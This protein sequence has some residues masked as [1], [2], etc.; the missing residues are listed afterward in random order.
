MYLLD[1]NVCIRFMTGRSAL[2]VRRMSGIA[3]TAVRLCS[4]VKAELL[5]GAR[6]SR[7]VA[8]NLAGLEEFWRPFASLPFDDIAAAHY[9]PIRAELSAAGTPIGPNDLMIAAIA[10]AHDLTLVTANTRE[11]RRVIGLRVEDWERPE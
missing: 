5:W 3:P 8:E 2:V 11:F 1:T 10:R 9:G 4:V 6:R 7:R